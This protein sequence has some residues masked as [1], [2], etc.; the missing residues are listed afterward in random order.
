MSLPRRPQLGSVIWVEVVDANGFRKVRPA[1]IVS[2]TADIEAGR[3]VRAAAITTRLPTPLPG[4]H[5]LLPWDP[6]GRARSGLRRKCAAVASWLSEISPGD[7]REVVG[8][9]PPPVIGELLTRISAPSAA[10]APTA[11]KAPAG[12]GTGPETGGP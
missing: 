3:P 11:D 5:V 1:V 7:I 12:G 10:P 9:L 4:D 8:I 6:Q 2:P